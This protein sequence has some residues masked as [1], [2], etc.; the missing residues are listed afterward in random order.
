M[1]ILDTMAEISTDLFDINKPDDALVLE[2]KR[3]ELVKVGI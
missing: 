2:T 1:S 3:M